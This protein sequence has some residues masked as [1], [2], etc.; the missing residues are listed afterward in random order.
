MLLILYKSIFTID[1]A[2]LGKNPTVEDINGQ[3]YGVESKSLEF[4]EA[5]CKKVEK[6]WKFQGVNSRESNYREILL[7]K[8]HV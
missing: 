5:Q 4:Q 3:F 1:W 6:F 8:E 7:K 2:I